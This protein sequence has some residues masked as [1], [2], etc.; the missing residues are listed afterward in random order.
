MADTQ[1]YENDATTENG[2][3]PWFL[4][5]ITISQTA[6]NNINYVSGKRYYIKIFG[7]PTATAAYPDK[8]SGTFKIAF[9]KNTSP[10]ITL[11]TENVTDLTANTWTAGDISSAFVEKWYKFT[12]NAN[13]QY[14]HFELGTMS[15]AFVQLYDDTGKTVGDSATIMSTT[16]NISRTVTNGSVYYVRVTA[17]AAG[18]YRIGFTN[19]TTPPPITLPTENVTPLTINTLSDGNI[20]T[21]GG[22][23]WFKFTAT[24]AAQFIHFRPGA[25]DDVYVQLY[26]STGTAVGDKTR[27]RD[28]TPFT[29]QTVTT[30]QDYYIKVTPYSSSK[31]GAYQ[32]TFSA[33]FMLGTAADLTEKV[34]A[35]G[36]LA[37]KTDEQWFK[38]TASAATQ[39]IHFKRGTL[40]GVDIQLYDTNGTKVG[41]KTDATSTR[42]ATLTVTSG[43]NYYF[44]VNTYTGLSGDGWDSGTYKITFSSS[45]T[46]PVPTD[47]TQLTSD[48]WADGE[49][50]SSGD[51]NWFKF[52]AG[53]ATTH[54]IHFYPGTVTYL[55]VQLFDA[56]GTKVSLNK[57]DGTPSGDYTYL[58]SSSAPYA[59]FIPANGKTY[60]IKVTPYSPYGTYQIGYNTGTT[61]PPLDLTKIT[62]TQLTAADTFVSGTFT[63]RNDEQWFKFT[64]AA[65]TQYILFKPGTTGT[66]L[67]NVFVQLYD[68]DGKKVGD[69]TQ[70][71]AAS[72]PLSRTVTTGDCYI[73]VT[74]SDTGTY[75]IAYSGTF[76]P[77][78]TVTD[79]TVGTTWTPAT[80][81]SSGEQW[82]KY[83]ADANATL[84]FHFKAGTTNALTSAYSQIYEDAASVGDSVLLNSRNPSFLTVTSGKTYYIKVS[85]YSSG[86]T[87]SYNIAL[88]DSPIPP[89]TT[90]TD[91]TVG[92]WKD[93]T[94]PANSS[95][96]QWFKFTATSDTQYIHLSPGGLTGADVQLYDVTTGAAVGETK[97]LSGSTLYVSRTVTTGKAYYI[98]VIPFMTTGTYKIGV[99]AST[100]PP[101]A[102]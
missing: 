23:Q 19:S 70:L 75:Q 64:A 12:A 38:F 85:R 56:D 97:Y 42:Y 82:F 100:T 1:L 18:T 41:N 63:N 49:L 84:Y 30:S 47:A 94:M 6:T 37:S 16:L 36:T 87:I 22:E 50:A 44:K 31:S 93:S 71:S 20:T 98:K 74:T 69:R 39:Y 48:K 99:T 91:I 65:T 62:P 72:S 80:L 54:Y 81:E 29:S 45:S 10:A 32:I 34:W 11:P 58:D 3:S 53:S 27:L 95:A 92:T 8:T 68:K 60:Y 101:P 51:E 15:M 21:A 33:S 73:K 76:T 5:S 66:A 35:D 46:T 43:Q 77:A 28:S 24:A 9:S 78:G 4:G 79:L 83:V 86:T 55:N 89:D 96:P 13:P 26:N 2:T 88:T 52:T 25:L 14:I 57:Y 102:Q 17:L 90:S 61:P 40:S 59:S 7:L 67:A